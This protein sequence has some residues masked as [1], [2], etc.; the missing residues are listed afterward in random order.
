MPSGLREIIYLSPKQRSIM[1]PYISPRARWHH[2]PNP[3][4]PQ[5]EGRII[6]EENDT[7]LFI[8]RLSPEKGAE[9]VARAAAIAGVPIAFA[10]EGACRDSVRRAN[11]DAQMLGWVGA[12]ELAAQMRRARCLLFP[13]LW[14]EAYALV[15]SDALRAGLPV[16]ASDTS[17]ATSLFRDGV[18][19]RHVK[20]GDAHAW[21]AAMT[22]LRSDEIAQSYSE[23]AFRTGQQLPGSDEC[24]T[25][26][27]E[28]YAAALSRK[29]EL[30]LAIQ[31]SIA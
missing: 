29:H 21:A 27:M 4:G 1:Q 13:S 7:F 14:Y 6:A 10:G 9:V 16:L 8:G 26:L 12:D 11:P 22:L 5:P 19:G 20:T 30:R 25:R 17:L 15:V 18:S 31:E 3:A 24:T 28:I 2:L 23:G